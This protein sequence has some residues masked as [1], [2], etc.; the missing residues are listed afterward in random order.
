MECV[1]EL[2]AAS[3]RVPEALQRD[4]LGAY[5]GVRARRLTVALAC[6]PNSGDAHFPKPDRS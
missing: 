1:N 4:Q 3:R 6:S 2:K 5:E